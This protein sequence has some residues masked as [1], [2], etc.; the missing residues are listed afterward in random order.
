MIRDTNPDYQDTPEGK[1]WEEWMYKSFIFC[2]EHGPHAYY[3]IET[4]EENR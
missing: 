1:E 2:E 4:L 3:T